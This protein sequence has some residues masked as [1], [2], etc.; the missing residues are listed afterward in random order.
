MSITDPAT[1]Q[2]IQS[3]SGYKAFVPNP[4][5]PEIAWD[6][7]LVMALSRAYYLL[8]QLAREGD[9][10]PNPHLFM[11][12]FMTREAV[13]SS[14]IE[15]TQA[16]ISDLLVDQVSADAQHD[17]DDL[18]EVRNYMSALDYGIE[19][20]NDLPLSLRLIKELHA[21]L[22]EGIRGSHAKP[23]AFRQI[24]NW[25][26]P[27]GSTLYTAHYVPPPPNYLMDCLSQLEAFLHDRQLPTL[28]HIGLCHYQF[29][30]IHPFLDG[31]GRIGRLL[32][33]L[34][35]VDRGILPSPLL[36]V[37]AFFEATKQ[38]YY[39]QLY[40]VSAYGTWRDWLVYFLNGVAV[41]CD[42]V[43]S[44]A[45]RINQL[46][47]DWKLQAAHS[48]SQIPV[49]IVERLTVNPYLT[50]KDVCTE[51]NIAFSTAQR[52]VTK[53]EAMTIIQQVGNNKRNR[54][55]CATQVLNILEEPTKLQ[56]DDYQDS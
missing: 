47:N 55:Y 19:R 22:M 3:P 4:L 32:I 31:N 10:L 12:A 11:K 34:L 25:I 45:E 18:Q 23:G 54:L 16:T 14:K 48:S 36:Y 9:T 20:L 8:G 37:S 15:G 52:W 44:R 43:L 5:P 30:A 21:H 46:I 26:G 41:Q 49:K 13:L 7:Q 24:Q 42:D 1:G 6:S 38:D 50:I 53:L 35:L 28:V 51:L 39:R 27:P 2:I 17:V 29:E 56:I 33:M 40:N